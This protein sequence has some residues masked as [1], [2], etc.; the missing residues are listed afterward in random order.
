MAVRE[1]VARCRHRHDLTGDSRVT[2]RRAA[3]LVRWP[4]RARVERDALARTASRRPLADDGLLDAGHRG[5]KLGVENGERTSGRTSNGRSI[6]GRKGGV[7]GP[8]RALVSCF[9]ARVCETRY[10]TDVSSRISSTRI[11]GSGP[12]SKGAMRHVCQACTQGEMSAGP[13]RLASASS[14]A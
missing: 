4:V 12:L 1:V 7:V 3:T 5:Y 8:R 14:R 9:V 2:A 10:D 11:C 13:V 6:R